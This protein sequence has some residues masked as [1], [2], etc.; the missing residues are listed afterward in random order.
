[1]DSLPECSQQ[2]DRTG[3]AIRSCFT[4]EEATAQRETDVTQLVKALAELES[5]P[6]GLEK[7]S[8]ALSWGCY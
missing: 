7:V 3:L 5:R 6:V 2:L 4:K 1:M 8:T